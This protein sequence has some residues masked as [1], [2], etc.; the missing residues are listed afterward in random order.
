MKV[1]SVTSECA[2]LVKTGGLADVAGA[3]PAALSEHGVEMRTLLPGYPA[4]MDA[5]EGAEAHFEVEGIGQVLGGRA[6]GLDLYVLDAPRFFSRPSLYVEA[7]GEGYWDNPQRFASL[8]RAAAGICSGAA[9]W[10]PEVAHCHDW[11]AGLLPVMTDTPCVLTIH[12]VA[13]QGNAPAERR[14]EM[15]VPDWAWHPGGAEFWGGVSTLK[16]GIVYAKAVTTVSPTYAREL[17]SPEFGLGLEGVLADKGVIGILNG[18]DEAEWAPPF[19]R[20]EDKAPHRAKLLEELRIEA[21]GPLACVVSRLT[22]QKG[23]DVLLSQLGD[24]VEMGGSLALLGSGEHGLEQGF[25]AARG[26]RVF[27]KLG[28][29]EGLARRL[30]AGS[31]AILV[32]SRFEPCGLTQL[33][34]LHHGTVPVVARTGGLA[35]TVIDANE[36]GLRAGAATGIMVTPGRGDALG[37]GLRLLCELFGGPR[38]LPMMEAGMRHPVGW[39]PSARRY[40]DLYEEIS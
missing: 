24:F 15:G 36:A 37:R 20:P 40:A 19:G 8:C 5:L 9:G 27:A 18:I 26:P 28:Y 33:Y 21:P 4:V 34:G 25:A 16:A 35:D 31:D 10:T 2:P 38:W 23:L 1:L 3:L 6:A 14:Y 39:G 13:F 7:D 29:D 11:Q 12:N 32:P 17:E 22:Y 30:I